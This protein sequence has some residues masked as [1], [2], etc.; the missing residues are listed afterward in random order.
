MLLYKP[1]NKIAVPGG[2]TTPVECNKVQL[3]LKMAMESV[4]WS[5]FQDYSNLLKFLVSA[6]HL[7]SRA[8][9]AWLAIHNNNNKIVT[10]L[11]W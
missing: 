1:V 10:Q 8:G 9:T 11:W 6:G 3:R 2:N 7:A 5:V 4:S